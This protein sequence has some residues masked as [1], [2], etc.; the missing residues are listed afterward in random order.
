MHPV[1]EADEATVDPFSSHMSGPELVPNYLVSRFAAQYRVVV[2]VLLAAQDSSLTGMSIEEIAA[3][4]RARLLRDVGEDVATQLLTDAR[5]HLDTRLR[6]AREVAGRHPLAG[7]G[8]TRRRL[9]APPRPIP[10][11]ATGRPA[12]HVL[13]RGP[14]R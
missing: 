12:A 7:A 13:A 3:A 4:V 1:D 14:R 11:D 10:V 5:Y 2:E 9:P 8:S 6:P